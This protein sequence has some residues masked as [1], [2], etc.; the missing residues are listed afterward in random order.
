MNNKHF[1]WKRF[2]YPRDGAISLSDGGYLYDPET[3]YGHIIN[4]H[5]VPFDKI[6][7]VPCLIL[8]GEPGSGKTEA[9]RNIINSEENKTLKLDLRSYGTEGRLIHNIFENPLFKACLKGECILHLFLDSLDECLLRI[10]YVAVL[11][12]EEFEKLKTNP[13]LKNLFLRIACRTADWPGL[14]ERELSGIWEEDNIQ[15]M[16]LAPLRRVDVYNA[17]TDL[18]ID[19]DKFMNELREKEVIPLAI[20]PITL[21]FLF[22][23][24]GR[25]GNF[26]STQKE[27]YSQGCELLCEETNESRVTS[28]NRGNSRAKDR[29]KVASRIAALMIFSNRY[30]VW[31]DTDFGNV[32]DEDIT[33]GD[34]SGEYLLQGDASIIISERE[35]EEVLSTGLFTSRGINRFGWVHQTYAEFLAALY[36]TQNELSPV[37]IMSLIEHPL[38]PERKL[39]PQLHEVS[40]WITT[41]NFEVFRQIIKCDPHVIL[42]SDVSNLDTE[43]KKKLVEALLELFNAEKMKDWELD[44][45]FYKLNHPF[46]IDQI[47]PC[48]FSIN[49]NHIA[50]RAALRIAR[51]CNLKE[52]QDD[53]LTI[54]LDQNEDYQIRVQASCAICEF[55]DDEIK[56]GLVPLANSEAGE[57]ADDQLKGVALQ[58]LWP[59]HIS[60]EVLFSLLAL[61]KRRHYSGQYR[62][63][64]HYEILDKLQVRDLPIALRWTLKHA[65]NERYDDRIDDLIYGIMNKAGSHLD[66][67]DILS[68]FTDVI[69]ARILHFDSFN[70]LSD[71]IQNEKIRRT[72]LTSLL[73]AIEKPEN[74]FYSSVCDH[75]SMPE[76]LPW[77]IEQ[78][79]NEV[80]VDIQRK[81][82][83][84]I[85]WIFNANNPKHVEVIQNAIEI[86]LLAQQ[87]PAFFLTIA[88]DSDLA[89]ELKEDYLRVKKRQEAR[90]NYPPIDPPIEARIFLR[91]EEFESGNLD[92]W[93]LLNYDLG[94]K[95]N[96]HVEENEVN[97]KALPNWEK[98]DS[99]AADR[100]LSAAKRYLVEINAETPNWFGTETFYRPAIA[101]YRAL[102]L[103]FEQE[104]E[105][106]QSLTSYHWENWSP[107]IL[108]Q[109]I[110]SENDEKIVRDQLLRLAYEKAPDKVISDLMLLIDK[111]NEKHSNVFVISAI[112]ECWDKRLGEAI[113]TKIKAHNLMP[114]SFERLLNELLKY[115]ISG[116][117]EFAK[118]LIS[119]ELIDDKD[120]RMKAIIAAAVLLNNSEFMVWNSVWSLKETDPDFVQDTIL[121]FSRRFEGHKLIQNL[122]ELELADLYIWFTHRFPHNEDPVHESGYAY[123]VGPREEIASFRDWILRYLTSRGTLES[124]AQISRIGLE[125]PE[126]SWLKWALIEAQE[127]TRRKTW[128]P[129]LPIEIIKLV[130]GKNSRFVQNEEQLMAVLIESLNRLEHNMHGITP[131]VTWLWNQI[132]SRKSKP[133]SENE[134]SDYVKQ[135]LERDL[136]GKGIVVNREVEI[137]S[138]VGSL[139]G[140]RT[141]IHVNAL[142]SESSTGDFK[143]ITVI[144]E[145]KGNWHRELFEAMETQLANRYLKEGKCR[146]GIYLV[147]WFESLKWDSTDNRKSTT[148]SCGLENTRVRLEDQAQS[149]SRKG[150][151]INSFVM[152]L[153]F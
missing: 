153:F 74:L 64:I 41:M 101:G 8:L 18:V 32:P 143:V 63:F 10:D 21:K 90:G 9:L 56:K 69:K 57:D 94:I 34:I 152:D 91:L 86:E 130:G 88:L 102:R 58:A 106:L 129:P 25:H 77:M 87:F 46:L 68:A 148:P 145:V 92:S 5:V 84:L 16:E 113:L 100:I 53:L 116:A 15:I 71:L 2:W 114:Q 33:I 98:V 35:I 4:K 133:K 141:D 75:L 95:V 103:V 118:S 79:Q 28:R 136:V 13:N 39:I 20:K 122:S 83:A 119:P 131:E 109:W 97:L 110:T 123:S 50:R 44:E 1:S 85:K 96:G 59:Q 11:L 7:G 128:A 120:A 62:M 42:R 67:P 51:A 81:W 150:I 80:I 93:W 124:C 31:R 22:N 89:R 38:D 17:A 72:L 149:L 70:Y 105:F 12:A 134:F 147:G 49:Y 45:Y 108:T 132:D 125:L 111:E 3:E 26:P 117:A 61:P 126:L 78:L 135:H 82:V 140:E 6:S 115:T 139:P 144:I 23:L 151:N 54:A 73:V 43:N 112:Q 52:L 27:L 47:K 99:C 138:S 48:L 121:S 24:Y 40:A 36:I 66:N 37:Q 137:R 19:V 29:L 30:G 107:V 76:D 60:A 14:L 142:L 55:A 65:V 104:F 127:L 146:Y